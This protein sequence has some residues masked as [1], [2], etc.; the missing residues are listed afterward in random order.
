MRIRLCAQFRSCFSQDR[1]FY[2]PGSN[3]RGHILVCVW[4]ILK[5]ELHVCSVCFSKRSW[6]ILVITYVLPYVLHHLIGPLNIIDQSYCKTHSFTRTC[7][8]VN[9]TVSRPVWKFTKPWKKEKGKWLSSLSSNTSGRA[10]DTAITNNHETDPIEKGRD[11]TQSFDKLTT[12]K[13]HQKFDYTTIFGQ[14]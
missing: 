8:T 10:P 4:V 1:S 14:T 7:F 11:L 3:D 13:R 12:Q 5:L 6:V 2:A 9:L